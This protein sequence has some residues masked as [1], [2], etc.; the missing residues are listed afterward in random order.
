MHFTSP[1]S[2]KI[3]YFQHIISKKVISELFSFLHPT[4]SKPV[5]YRFYT[6]STSQFRLATFHV[7]HSW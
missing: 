3:L 5:S 6:Y 1:N 4:S 2:L 7:L